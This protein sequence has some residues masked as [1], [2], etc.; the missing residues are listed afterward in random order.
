VYKEFL[1]H[2]YSLIIFWT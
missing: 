2:S 1:A